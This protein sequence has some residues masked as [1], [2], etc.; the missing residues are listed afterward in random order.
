DLLEELGADSLA[1]IEGA[2]LTAA[3]NTHVIAGANVRAEDL[4]NSV[5]STLGEDI[6]I[7]ATNGTV[8]DNNGRVS[9]IIVTN[10]QAANG[11]VHAIDTVLLP[12][13]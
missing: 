9:T 12:T 7:D 4:T 3:L 6:T 11:V 2:V 1:D 8:T 5:V 13:L 10:V